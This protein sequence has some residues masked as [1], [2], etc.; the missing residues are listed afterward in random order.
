MSEQTSQLQDE[1][2]LSSPTDH[3]PESSSLQED[4]PSDVEKPEESTE[5]F[6]PGWRFVAAFVSLSVITLMA[7]LD[8][9]SISVALPVSLLQS[10]MNRRHG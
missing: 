10:F 5:T 8:A 4:L 1:L 7:A 3:S 2:K 9:T 6:N